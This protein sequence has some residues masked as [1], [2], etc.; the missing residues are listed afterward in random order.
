VA[1]TD[2]WWDATTGLCSD[3]IRFD[4][5]LG[6]PGER[7]AAEF[8]AALLSDVGLAC[9]I[10]ESERGRANLICR[11]P[12][13]DNALDPLLIHMHL[14]VVPAVPSDWTVHP[15]SGE[16]LDEYVW[17][18]GAV[19]MKNM[20]ASVITIVRERVRN[21]RLPK[22]PLVLAFLADEENAGVLGAEWLVQHHPEV[23]EGC[24]TAIG[25]GG[26]WSI[27]VANEQ[28]IYPV[29]S[30]EKG[31][32]ALEVTA[33]ARPAHASRLYDHNPVRVLGEAIG[34][35]TADRF[36]IHLTP[37]VE[38]L[39]RALCEVN[40]ATFDPNDPEA[41]LQFAGTEADNLA[42]GLRNTAH[43]TRLRAGYQS[44]VIP[45][46]ATAE[47]DVRYLPG[48]WE[49]FWG[50]LTAV[51]GDQVEI[52]Q[53]AR[54]AGLTPTV[55]SASSRIWAT[56]LEAV[57][58]QDPTARCSPFML[59]GGTDATHLQRLGIEC[60]GFNPLL[61]PHDL[62]FWSLFHSTDERIPI[63]SLHFN[64]QVI[65]RFLDLF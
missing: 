54:T 34:R 53:L 45:G 65:D 62:D 18:R 58:S 28:R 64:A 57:Q 20:V 51:L 32:A 22:R 36:P 60:F 21:G 12:G 27:A 7:G 38:A 11:V 26:G 17:G 50:E 24:R 43:A 19:D 56:A 5:Q 33:S 59:S 52:V 48:R 40:G 35:L 46:S 30:A 49:E 37:P 55:D 10:L 23:F 9:T 39:L 42:S 3:L 13:R 25:E 61:L 44:N 1:T 15:L 14:D 47:L 63:E 2:N 6:G 8:V 31:W 16:V 29:H 4:T 41:S